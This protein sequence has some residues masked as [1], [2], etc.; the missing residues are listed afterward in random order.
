MSVAP[1]SPPHR[2][3]CTSRASPLKYTRSAHATLTHESSNQML[4]I[5]RSE[6]GPRPVRRVNV[7]LFNDSLTCQTHALRIRILLFYPA[8]SCQGI[9]LLVPC[10]VNRQMLTHVIVGFLHEHTC[11]MWGDAGAQPPPLTYKARH[12]PQ[13]TIALHHV[14]CC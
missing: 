7:R 1:D 14:G 6:T 5:T 12:P 9:L 8:Q 4:T 13:P 10:T 3:S 11:N 2:S